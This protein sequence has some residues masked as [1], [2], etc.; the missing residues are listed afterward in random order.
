MLKKRAQEAAPEALIDFQRSLETFYNFP[1]QLVFVSESSKDGRAL[2][3]R[4][5]WS[6]PNKPVIIR[7]PLRQGTPGSALTAKNK[8]SP[9]G[10]ATAAG[11]FTRASLQTAFAKDIL[12]F[13]NPYPF[14]NSIVIMDSAR[15]HMT[16]ELDDAIASRGAL[17]FHFHPPHFNPLE[18]ATLAA[19]D[20]DDDVG[21][22]DKEFKAMV[23]LIVAGLMRQR[24]AVVRQDRK[25]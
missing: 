5:A 1:E 11:T 22:A 19:E 25:R 4:Y 7:C 16:V 14:H 24:E 2:L 3:R 21:P 9:R 8:A 20:K 18:V 6:T 13:L 12:P 15:V 17:S 10:R 23:T